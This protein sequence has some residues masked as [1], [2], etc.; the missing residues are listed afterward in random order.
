MYTEDEE[1]LRGTLYVGIVLI[2]LYC[3]IYVFH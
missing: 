2:T 1:F 3:I